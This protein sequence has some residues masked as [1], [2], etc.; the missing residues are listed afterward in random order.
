MTAIYATLGAV[1]GLEGGQKL[2]DWQST[3][4]AP[5]DRRERMARAVADLGVDSEGGMVRRDEYLRRLE[6]MVYGDDPREGYFDADVFLHPGLKFRVDLPPI[7]TRRNLKDA[8]VLQSP[9]ADA[10]AQLT[11]TNAATPSAAAEAF[12]ARPGVRRG[13][14]KSERLHGLDTVTGDFELGDATQS[15]LG[16][17]TFAAHG[18]KVY[19]LAGFGRASAWG[20]RREAARIPLRS[21]RPL[22][23]AKVL[24]V[25]PARIRIVRIERDMSLEEFQARHPSSASP[26]RIAVL[27]HVPVGGRLEAGAAVKRVVG[28][29]GAK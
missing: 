3:H 9:Q 1:A 4:P 29:A 2:P 13:A 11:L 17:V 28:G 21:F 26:E 19:Q 8:L 24:A 25:E 7:W 14:V 18:G 6:G 10:A 16:E 12:F 15:L 22:T 5:E 20:A 23:D 27:N